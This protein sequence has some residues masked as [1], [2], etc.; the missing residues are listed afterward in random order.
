[1]RLREDSLS[2]DGTNDCGGC[3]TH[4]QYLTN[5]E[6]KHQLSPNGGRCVI[7]DSYEDYDDDSSDRVPLVLNT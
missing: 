2:C 1:M 4:L 7:E 6:E 5:S 3:D